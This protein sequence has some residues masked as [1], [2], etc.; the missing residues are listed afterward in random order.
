MRPRRLSKTLRQATH[1][2]RSAFY[3]LGQANEPD[4]EFVD[5]FSKRHDETVVNLLRRLGR[6]RHPAD[7]HQFDLFAPTRHAPPD[8]AR[9]YQPRRLS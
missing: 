4:E 1:R 2:R 7:P 8:D 6:P 9:A 5:P 3:V